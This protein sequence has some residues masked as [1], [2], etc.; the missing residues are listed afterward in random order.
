MTALSNF[1]FVKLDPFN[2][3]FVKSTF[4]KLAFCKFAPSKFALDILE[5][6]K[7]AF[8][9]SAFFNLAFSKLK[10]GN[11][12]LSPSAPFSKRSLIIFS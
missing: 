7:Y 4:D 5:P 1:V 12:I 9:N 2:V 10:S 3:A 8:F 6:Y 11:A